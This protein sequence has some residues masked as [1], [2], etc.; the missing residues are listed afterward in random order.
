MRFAVIMAGGTG[1]RFWPESRVS[2]PKQFLKL[3][4][5]KT[6]LQTTV[7]RINKLVP[8]ENILVITNS[9]Y[10]SLVKEQ[11]PQLPDNN[12]VG[13]II[14][15]NTAPCVAAATAIVL[16][17]DSDASMVVLPSDHYIRDEA[18]FLSIVEA[19]FD[20]AANDHC[21]ITIGI[22]PYRPE[23]GY[24]YIQ[25]DDTTKQEVNGKPV[26][27]V[28]TF[29]E[30]PDLETAVRFLESG[31]FLWN[32]GMFIWRAK[33]I[34][35]EFEKYLKPMF[36]EAEKLK[37][38]Y[39]KTPK[40]A[41]D[42]FFQIVTSISIDY[43]IMEKTDAV[44]VLP[45]EFGWNDVG[46]WLAIYELEE[47]QDR[48]NVVRKGE[49][50]FENCENCFVSSVSGKLVSM[51][52]LQGIGFVETDDAIMLCRMERSQ[53]VRDIVKRLEEDKFSKYK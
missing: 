50:L 52:G 36:D 14:G 48:G 45:G 1:T 47:K 11:V 20:K 33:D 19:G 21:L 24:G 16:N 38:T 41:V 6:M 25:F 2:K 46:S 42:A 10:V 28:K 43:G 12:I 13:E 49:A 17:R 30:K 22:T 40:E 53:D 51:V 7:E 34:W 27:Q 3:I 39:E 29:A 44:F 26:Y 8:T 5:E 23:T 37:Q 18:T 4:G 35:A 15:K 32:S 9:A 31:D